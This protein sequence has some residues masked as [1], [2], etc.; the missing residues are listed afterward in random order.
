MTISH[1]FFDVGGVLGSGG[2]SGTHRELAAVRFGI[3]G[4]EL[5][6][7][8]Q[9]V[10]SMWET[11]RI[12]LDEYLGCT[13]FSQPRSFSR[14]DFIAFMYSCSAPYDD[15]IAFA[16]ALARTGRFRMMTLNNESEPLNVHRIRRFGLA[17]IFEAFF[18]SCWLGVAKPSRRIYELAL[19][20]AQAEP[21]STVFIDDRPENVEPA[22]AL[23][24]HAIRFTSLPELRTALA[25]LGVTL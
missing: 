17:P 1:F 7:R 19:A 8:H 13:V 4:A 23:G 10:A 6:R 18:S 9:L 16:A 22:R 5:E 11:G 25:G 2:W 14:E 15:H 12:S 21:A 24:L 3:D 20:L